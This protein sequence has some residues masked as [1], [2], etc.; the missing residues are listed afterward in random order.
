MLAMGPIIN[1]KILSTMAL[2]DGS[3]RYESWL[4]PPVQPHLEGYAFNVKNPQ[5]VLAG[6]KPILEEVGPFVYKSTTLKD[7]DN[8]VRFWEDATLTYRPRKVE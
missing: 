2:I 1:K 8:N 3:E 6:K 4:R 5:A 7:S